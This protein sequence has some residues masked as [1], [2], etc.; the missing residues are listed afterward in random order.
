MNLHTAFL[1]RNSEIFIY[2]KVNLKKLLKLKKNERNEKQ[3]K[4]SLKI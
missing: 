1:Y 4:K 2:K 3:L